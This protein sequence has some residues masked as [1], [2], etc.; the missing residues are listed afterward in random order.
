MF[1]SHTPAT[2]ELAEY[3]GAPDIGA[4]CLV[5]YEVWRGLPLEC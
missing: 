5:Q 4:Q 3:D 1:Y 2:G